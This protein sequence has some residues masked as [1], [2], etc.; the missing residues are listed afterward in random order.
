MSKGERRLGKK[1]LKEMQ[2][3]GEKT[4]WNISVEEEKEDDVTNKT[5]EE[6]KRS[7]QKDENNNNK[8]MKK[9]EKG[10]YNKQVKELQEI[11][12]RQEETERKQKEGEKKKSPELGEKLEEEKRKKTELRKS[13]IYRR[14]YDKE[15]F[16]VDKD[17][18]KSIQGIFEEQMKD[19]LVSQGKE[20][21]KEQI[22]NYPD[23]YPELAGQDIDEFDE[24]RIMDCVKDKNEFWGLLDK[25][26]KEWKD[27]ENLK[28]EIE[29]FGEDLPPDIKTAIFKRLPDSQIRE[30]VWEK[31]TGENLNEKTKIE[32]GIGEKNDYIE[33]RIEDFKIEERNKF[34]EEEWNELSPE[35]QKAAGSINDYAQSRITYLQETL[36]RNLKGLK[37]IEESDILGLLEQG[38]GP[39]KIEKMKTARKIIPELITARKIKIEGVK[40]KKT[41]SVLEEMIKN[42][43]ESRIG[44]INEK[45]SIEEENWE[46]IFKDK[47]S[48]I[49][50]EEREKTTDEMIE[51]CYEKMGRE[52]AERGL[53]KEI[54]EDPKRKARIEKE[55]GRGKK[56]KE[57]LKKEFTKLIKKDEELKGEWEEDEENLEEILEGWGIEPEK[58]SEEQKEVYEQFSEK[59][60]GL[61]DWILAIIFGEI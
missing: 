57:N 32:A 29:Y 54:D 42:G 43:N 34:F 10:K 40:G 48:E 24:S 41:I 46:D 4:G 14:F 12:A 59:K 2:E 28:E 50:E 5:K 1:I 47:K 26:N 53:E 49:L 13:E 30:K 35:Q 25:E 56:G 61:V 27:A 33:K 21:L 19:I 38:A 16:S 31:L 52:V 36:N 18:I 51:R 60:Y 6:L 7:D 39:E 9:Q 45:K 58:L 23:D 3:A 20:W 55:F 8:N 11:V 15:R 22:E 37:N 17:T 44:K